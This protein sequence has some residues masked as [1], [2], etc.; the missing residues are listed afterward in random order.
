MSLSVKLT[1]ESVWANPCV[2]TD[3]FLISV[4]LNNPILE[5]I[6]QREFYFWVFCFVNFVIFRLA[7]TQEFRHTKRET[8]KYTRQDGVLTWR[9]KKEKEFGFLFRNVSARD[10]FPVCRRGGIPRPTSV[11][12]QIVCLVSFEMETYTGECTRTHTPV[13]HIHSHTTHTRL[14]GAPVLGLGARYTRLNSW[15]GLERLEIL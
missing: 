12:N 8:Q 1:F 11:N 13:T 3:E 10:C 7:H 6:P 15:N 14:S 4:V 9:K 5:I 2:L